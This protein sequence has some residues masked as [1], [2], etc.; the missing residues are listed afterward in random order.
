MEASGIL[1]AGIRRT[2]QWIVIKAVCDYGHEKSTDKD[3][4]QRLA[5]DVAAQAFVHV[6][7]SGAFALK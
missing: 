3:V 2:I 6:L 7:M 5:A 1:S 4:R